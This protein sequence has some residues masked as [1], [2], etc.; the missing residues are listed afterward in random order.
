VLAGL[1]G[2]AVPSRSG[3]PAP[4]AMGF[5]QAPTLSILDRCR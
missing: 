1:I 3:S 2:S 4:L 5:A